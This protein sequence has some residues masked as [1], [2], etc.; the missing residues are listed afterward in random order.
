MIIGSPGASVLLQL[1]L[2]DGA[3]GLFPRA[4]VYDSGGLLLMSVDLSH[5]S[6]GL[7]TSTYATPA[8]A[9]RFSVLYRVFT[10]S[11]HTILDTSYTIVCDEIDTESVDTIIT[12]ATVVGSGLDPSV[13]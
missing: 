12:P 2:S 3:A 7:Y 6:N 11:G 13:R 9:G 8:T 10:D 4:E 5:I 1:A